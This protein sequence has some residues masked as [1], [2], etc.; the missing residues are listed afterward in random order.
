MA[1]EAKQDTMTRFWRNS[2]YR[3]SPLGDTHWVEGHWVERED[4]D[5]SSGYSHSS[6]AREHLSSLGVLGS[7]SSRYVNPNA[8]CPVCGEDVFFYQNEYGSRVYFDELGPPWPKHPCTDNSAYQFSRKSTS[9]GVICPDLRDRESISDEDYWFTQLP[10]TPED[11]FRDTY[12]T[13]PWAFWEV[14]KRVK[15]VGK[16]LLILKGVDEEKQM[17]LAA[18]RLPR[19]IKPGLMVFYK[20][21]RLAYFDTTAMEPAECSVERLSAKD[22]IETQF[23]L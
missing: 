7:S 18:E 6:Y 1:L 21:L 8:K 2:Y 19:I 13:K 9:R 3:T 5:R 11:E 22:F 4:W 12:G 14:F 10:W 16:T 15:G 23:G 20:R 17:Y